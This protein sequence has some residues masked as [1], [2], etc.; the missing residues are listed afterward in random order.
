VNAGLIS[1]FDLAGYRKGPVYIRG[2]RH[3]APASEQLMDCMTALKECM[4]EEA[5]FAV[6]AILGHLFMGYI[7][8][9]PDGNGRSARFLMIFLFIVGG[10]RWVVINQEARARYLAALESASVGK[11]I[12]PFVKFTLESIDAAE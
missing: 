11:G 12:G 10:S 4:I 1:E 6:K 3:V 5:S 9:F 8:P 7:H 2:S